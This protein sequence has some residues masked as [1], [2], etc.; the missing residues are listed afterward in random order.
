MSE[1]VNRLFTPIPLASIALA[2]V[3]FGGLYNNV[4]TIGDEV[5]LIRTDIRERTRDRIY[6]KEHERDIQMLDDR[7]SRVE[8]AMYGHDDGGAE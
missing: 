8:R 5:M 2:L 6:R 7:L 1:I 3:S 4:D